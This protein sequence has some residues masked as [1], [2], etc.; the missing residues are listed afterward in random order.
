MKMTILSMEYSNIRKFSS[1]KVDFCNEHGFPHKNTFIMMGNG[2]GKTTTITLIKGLLDGSAAAWNAET[3]RSFAP[4]KGTA[5][6]GSFKLSVK[7]DEAIYIYVLS[8]DYNA[9]KAVIGCTTSSQGGLGPRKFPKALENLFTQEFVRRFVFDGEQATKAMDTNSNEADD[10]I[11]YLYRLDVFDAIARNNQHILSAIQDA[12]GGARGTSQ[13]VTN[14]RSRQ[15]RIKDYISRLETRQRNL[16]KDVDELQKQQSELETQIAQYD[17]KYR[18]FN[19]DKLEAKARCEQIRNDIN[20]QISQIMDMVRIPYYASPELCQRMYDFGNSMTKLKLPKTISKDFFRE[21][22]EAPTCICGHSI[23]EKERDTILKN[24]DL[25]LGSDQQSVL[26]NI[27]SNLMNSTYDSRLSD[28]F[29]TLTQLIADLKIAQDNL[30][31]AEEKLTK[32]GGEEA[33]RM[34][35]QRDQLIADISHKETE[36]SIIMSKD[37]NDPSLTEES[38]LNKARTAYADLESK[39]ASATRTNEA[40]RHKELIDSLIQD[41]KRTATRRLKQEIIRKTNEKLKSVILDDIIEIES[42]DR[43]IRLKGK[44]GASEGQTLSIAYCF[45]GTMFEDSELQFP[46]VI[47]SPAGKM[48]YEKRRAVAGI[49][50]SLFN[51]LISFV[52]SAEVEQFADQFYGAADSQFLTIIANPNSSSIEIHSGKDYFDTYQ[53]EH[54]EEEEYA[55]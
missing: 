15:N 19:R 35:E 7:F 27:K 31:V 12:E 43:F 20:L 38:N 55:L 2:T 3:V 24:A 25:Y 14:L 29:D 36:I 13:S 21:L 1:L 45:L 18:S 47:D 10:A 46:F 4:S 6:T 33:I 26:N 44:A 22:A 16:R 23:G 54:R 50:P 17:E 51:Q 40:L 52:T 48:D 28:A 53:R 34:R 42:I 8:F 5:S 32:A 37:E 49:L 39:I 9:G 30:L 41:I 11:K